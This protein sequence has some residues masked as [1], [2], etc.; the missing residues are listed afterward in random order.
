MATDT[1]DQQQDAQQADAEPGEFIVLRTVDATPEQVWRAWT[2]EPFVRQWWGPTG[3]TCPRADMDVRV[4]GTTL[5]AMQ[6]PPEWGGMLFHNGWTYT[7]L[8]APARLE[9]TSSFVDAEGQQV[10]PAQLG[11]PGGVPLGVPHVVTIT[12]LADGRTEMRVAESGYTDPAAVQQSQ[13]GQEQCM[14]KLVAS[15]DR[16]ASAT[17]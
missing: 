12:A 1:D 5:V 8:E 16:R 15:L 10:D 2:E 17:G 13:A 7:L 4:G 3:F 6:A 9:F 14:D 11:I